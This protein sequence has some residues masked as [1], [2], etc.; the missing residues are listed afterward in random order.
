M[1]QPYECQRHKSASSRWRSTAKRRERRTKLREAKT[2]APREYRIQVVSHCQTCVKEDIW[3]N[4]P[5]SLNWGI[6]TTVYE[7]KSELLWH[8]QSG[9]RKEKSVSYKK[10]SFKI[11]RLE[12]TLDA[13]LTICFHFR[14]PSR[15][16][17]AKTEL[18]KGTSLSGTEPLSLVLPP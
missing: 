16:T 11:S 5:Q 1:R 17:I 10:R 6:C 2:K 9:R 14:A 12:S 3:H 15:H 18:K 4:Q 7:D 13:A 8:V